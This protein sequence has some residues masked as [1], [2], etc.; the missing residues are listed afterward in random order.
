MHVTLG[1]I[2]VASPRKEW[3][4]TCIAV[5]CPP[6]PSAHIVKRGKT[7]RGPQCDLCQHTLCT[8]GRCLLAS[9][10][11]GCLP[12]VKPTLIDRRLHASGG[13]DT[14]RSWPI[15][16]Q[17]ILRALKKR[18]GVLAAVHPTVLRPLPPAEVAWD[19]ERAGQAEAARE[20]RG[21]FGGAT[22][23]LRWLWHAIEHHP[24]QVVASIFGRRQEE[25]CWRLKARLE[26]CR[27]TRS[28]TDY[29]GA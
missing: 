11:R 13:R 24:G 10:H 15:C 5:R 16:P 19:V 9:G 2:C 6:C 22:G 7:A 4:M 3:P 17:T 1:L 18:A 12:A 21:S 28:Y 29:W 23:K 27:L 14:A 26:S 25:V 20:E 8:Q